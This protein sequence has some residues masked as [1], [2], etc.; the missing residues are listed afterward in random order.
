[1]TYGML[2]DL[3]KCVAVMLCS[4]ACKRPRHRERAPIPSGAHFRGYLSERAQDRSAHAVHA[5]RD[6]LLRGGVP[7]G[8][9]LKRD[10]GIVVIDK[11][12]CI[13]CGA[14]RLRAYDARHLAASE[15]G[16]PVRAERVRGGDVRSDAPG[17]HGQVPSAPSAS[18]LGREAGL[19]G[20]LPGGARV[21]GELDDIRA[22]AEAAGGYQLLPRRA[23]TLGAVLPFKVNE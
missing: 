9:H 4:V 17:D 16:Y 21:F 5:L 22:E 8:R 10:D 20:R 11:D 13:G 23:R 15:D 7:A 6:A 3:K 2:I 19:R 14:C 1:M 18:I 12:K